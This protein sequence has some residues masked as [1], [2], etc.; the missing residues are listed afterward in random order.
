M[1]PVDAWRRC[2]Q[3]RGEGL[4]VT[5]ISSSTTLEHA[6]LCLE[7]CRYVIYRSDLS[8]CMPIVCIHFSVVYQNALTCNLDSDSPVLCCR[9]LELLGPWRVSC[10][11]GEALDFLTTI[12]SIICGSLVENLDSRD[13]RHQVFDLTTPLPCVERAHHYCV[14]LCT[15]YIQVVMQK[16]AFGPAEKVVSIMAGVEVSEGAVGY[17]PWILALHGIHDSNNRFT[18]V[19]YTHFIYHKGKVWAQPHPQ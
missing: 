11:F 1:P 10:F 19:I 6:L 4:S 16:S 17:L 18:R 14:S 7:S 13:S 5:S 8:G 12:E 2:R 15:D 3:S 9:F